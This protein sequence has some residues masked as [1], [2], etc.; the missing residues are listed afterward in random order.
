MRARG[1]GGFLP[2]SVV[3]PNCALIV[4]HGGSRTTASPLHHAVPRLVPPSF[5]DNPMSARWVAD[6]D[7]G[8]FLE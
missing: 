7:V 8:L 6:R 2:L 3:L 5:A 4:H 1:I